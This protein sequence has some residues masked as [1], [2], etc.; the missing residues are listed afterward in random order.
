MEVL[1]T[2]KNISEFLWS[3]VPL[4]KQMA[5]FWSD[6]SGRAGSGCGA[7]VTASYLFLWLCS[8]ALTHN[9]AWQS[10]CKGAKVVSA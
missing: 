3:N 6:F 7:A 10:L 8:P 9:C 1:E 5:V 2:W 4:G